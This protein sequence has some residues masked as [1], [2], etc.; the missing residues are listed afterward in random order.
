[1]EDLAVTPFTLFSSGL[2]WDRFL[3]DLRSFV[4]TRFRYKLMYYYFYH[5]STLCEIIQFLRKIA[6]FIF[7]KWKLWA[8]FFGRFLRW[9]NY[10]RKKLRQEKKGTVLVFLASVLECHHILYF[11]KWKLWA[12]FLAGSF[13]DQITT[14]KKGTVCRLEWH[15][16]LSKKIM[17]FSLSNI[18]TQWFFF[19]VDT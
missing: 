8:M 10:D 13:V 17:A 18:E 12:M 15:Y 5:R 16:Q 6:Y 3:L 9:W 1:M 19:Q 14:K 11:E 7:W 4:G 2:F